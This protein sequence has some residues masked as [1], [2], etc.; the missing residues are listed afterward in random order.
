M[1]GRWQG[2]W[3]ARCHL[4]SKFL[5][6][7][8]FCCWLY[9]FAQ[10]SYHRRRAPPQQ[11]RILLVANMQYA[12]HL[13]LRTPNQNQ[14]R[15]AWFSVLHTK[16]PASLVLAYHTTHLFNDPIRLTSCVPSTPSAMNFRPP[17]E[18]KPARLVLVFLVSIPRPRS[19]SQ[20]PAPTTSVT[21][22]ASGNLLGT[23]D[24]ASGTPTAILFYLFTIN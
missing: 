1:R 13:R 7:L 6:N 12:L 4:F 21:L 14:G 8:L 24:R 10:F 2:T 18:T 9:R 15:A 3:Y 16:T 11:Q 22:Y 23:E 19:F 17:I 20:F 5:F